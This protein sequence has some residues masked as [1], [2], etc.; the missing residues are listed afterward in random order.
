MTPRI[1]KAIDIFLDA[2]NK[3]ELG[4]GN[5]RMCAVG[6]LVK[7]AN[8]PESKDNI[9]R[10]TEIHARW[11]PLFYTIEHGR[12]E[13]YTGYGEEIMEAKRV[14]SYTDFTEDELAKIENVFERNTKIHYIVYPFCRPQSIRRDQIAGLK[15]VVSTM[16][17]FENQEDDVQE[18]FVKRAEEI[19]L[20]V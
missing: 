18:V 11:S 6:N 17:S 12:Q 7:A 16:L 14:I 8:V 19:P 3:G 2:L 1:Q 9:N 13:V 5:C 4:K 15:A 10:T 20:V